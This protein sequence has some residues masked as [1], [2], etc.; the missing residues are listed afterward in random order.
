M[1]GIEKTVRIVDPKGKVLAEMSKIMKDV[2]V[3]EFKKLLVKFNPFRKSRKN[4]Y[5]CAVEEGVP[6]SH[7]LPGPEL[8]SN[9]E[10][11]NSA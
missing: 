5:C 3:E 9:F 11:L 1:A 6:L 7:Y 10:K 4:D 2:S 8:I